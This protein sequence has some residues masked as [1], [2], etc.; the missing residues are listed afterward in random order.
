[1]KNKKYKPTKQELIESRQRLAIICCARSGIITCDGANKNIP[2]EFKDKLRKLDELLHDCQ[3]LC[4][5]D[6][7]EENTV[8][9]LLQVF[10][11]SLRLHKLDGVGDIITTLAVTQTALQNLQEFSSG[12]LL[13]SL[14]PIIDIVDGLNGEMQ[15]GCK[16]KY[17]IEKFDKADEIVAIL[18]RI[19]N[20]KG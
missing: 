19:I 17:L 12:E 15:N 9:S 20:F 7:F 1:M 11:S 13:D 3:S 2:Q 6:A 4:G 8:R 16:D 5:C 10:Q 18:F 14:P